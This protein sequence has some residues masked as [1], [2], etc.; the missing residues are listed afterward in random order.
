M[1]ADPGAPTLFFVNLNGW[2][3]A[4]KHVAA[5]VINSDVVNQ[6]THLLPGKLF[7]YGLKRLKVA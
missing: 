7:K 3:L 6:R 2:A 4:C 1:N 5:L